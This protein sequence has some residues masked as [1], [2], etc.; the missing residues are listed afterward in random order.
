MR[1][2]GLKIPVVGASDAHKARKNA[3]GLFDVNFSI[4]FAADFDEIKSAIKDERSVAVERFPSSDFRAVGR[5]RYV[6]YA[7]F[8]LSEYFPRRDT[9]TER[10]ADALASCDARTEK[11]ILAE[12][13]IE[14][15]DK[16]FFN[17]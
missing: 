9:L 10:H 16:R 2:E 17:L 14:A 7:R 13:A 11:I 4:I 6:K 15:F 1:A 3:E 12:G 8:L 5:F